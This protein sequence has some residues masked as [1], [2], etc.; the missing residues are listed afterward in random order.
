MI[1]PRKLQRAIL[2][3]IHEGHQGKVKS[4]DRFIKMA[5]VI[6]SSIRDQMLPY[7]YHM[8]SVGKEG[9]MPEI[10]QQTLW[11]YGANGKG[12]L[13]VHG[14]IGWTVASVWEMLSPGRFEWFVK[15]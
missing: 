2:E 13:N 4:R 3:R 9:F 1:I 12:F 7:P 15:G 10:I 11:D 6:E 8:V 14:S 5:D